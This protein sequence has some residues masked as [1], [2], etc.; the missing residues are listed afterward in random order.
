MADL[1]NRTVAVIATNG[2]EDSELT[3]PVE[4]VKKAGATVKVLST[5]AGTIEGKNGTKIDVDTT[6]GLAV[7]NEFDALLL[8]GGTGNADKIRMDEDAVALT[9]AVVE[10]GKPVAVICHGAWIL[11]EADAVRGLSL[12]HI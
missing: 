7:A 8:P 11:T 4:E 2:F 9:R 12:I 10:A 3:S 6:T 1:S 5:E